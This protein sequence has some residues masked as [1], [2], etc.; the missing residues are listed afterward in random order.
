MY[1]YKVEAYRKDTGRLECIRKFPKPYRKRDDEKA[2]AFLCEQV[3][4]AEY[5][6]CLTVF[7]IRKTNCCIRAEYLIDGDNRQMTKKY[8]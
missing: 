5:Q 1:I 7:A 2:I 8:L 4:T 6:I 3:N